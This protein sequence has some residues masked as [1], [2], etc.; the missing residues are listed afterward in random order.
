MTKDTSLVRNTN[1]AL[2]LMF[3]KTL[4]KMKKYAVMA[5]MISLETKLSRDYSSR[6]DWVFIPET[7]FTSGLGVA[8]P[9]GS[10]Y[11]KMFDN[12]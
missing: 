11:K 12:A 5:D 9:E 6:C 7:F 8:L 2:K 4:N 3:T 10:P 1:A